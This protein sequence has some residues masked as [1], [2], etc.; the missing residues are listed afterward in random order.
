MAPPSDE[1]PHPEG[2]RA[3]LRV[4][5]APGGDRCLFEVVDRRGR[6]LAHVALETPELDSL[7]RSLADLRAAMG[8]P[9]PATLDP[10]ARLTV[11]VDPA[12]QTRLPAAGTG[13]EG[14]AAAVLA[15]RHPGLGWLGFLLPRA[16]AAALGHSLT[17]L[18]AGQEQRTHQLGP[19]TVTFTVTPAVPPPSRP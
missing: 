6:A 7:V 14:G 12:W 18:A 17:R 13:P 5:V 1:T 10:G 8:D 19:A 9:V 15:L 2:H 11:L 3:G 16:E 4:R